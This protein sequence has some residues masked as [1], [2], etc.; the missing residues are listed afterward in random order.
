MNSEFYDDFQWEYEPDLH[1]I[2]PDEAFD[3]EGNLDPYYLEEIDNRQ[4]LDAMYRSS[5]I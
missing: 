1:D 5:V 2:Y 3:E 4:Y